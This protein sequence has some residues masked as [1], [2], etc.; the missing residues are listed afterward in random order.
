[1]PATYPAKLVTTDQTTDQTTHHTTPHTP[2]S[3]ACSKQTQAP[4]PPK[5]TCTE[6]ISSL[7]KAWPGFG[8]CLDGGNEASR[9][10]TSPYKVTTPY[11][12]TK[13]IMKSA[14][15][16]VMKK[17]VKMYSNKENEIECEYCDMKFSVKIC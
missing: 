13:P 9:K 11:K 12:V 5:Q 17:K 6:P 4:I 7:S 14:K 15:S 1:M 2:I 16:N 10:V 8:T 3:L